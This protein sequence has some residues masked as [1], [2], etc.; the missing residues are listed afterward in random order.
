LLESVL[1]PISAVLCTSA[2]QEP[3]LAPRGLPGDLFDEFRVGNGLMFTNEAVF[4]EHV[5][6]DAID[7]IRPLAFDVMPH[8]SLKTFVR[9]N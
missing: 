1:P 2:T 3:R 8:G 6:Y 9:T 4:L 7:L 5:G